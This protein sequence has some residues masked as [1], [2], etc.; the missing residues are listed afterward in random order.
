[1]RA[2]VAARPTFDK[3]VQCFETSS[4]R[5]G[6][7]PSGLQPLAVRL[8]EALCGPSC[9]RRHAVPLLRATLNLEG[10]DTIA[11]HGCVRD[12]GAALLALLAPLGLSP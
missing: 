1:V 12:D 6:G 3:P 5:L 8:E 10:I 11:L 4:G 2:A 7:R 9:R